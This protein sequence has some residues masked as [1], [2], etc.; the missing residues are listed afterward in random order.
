MKTGRRPVEIGV[1]LPGDAPGFSVK[2]ANH[3]VAGTDEEEIARDRGGREDSSARIKL[4]EDVRLNREFGVGSD[5][6]RRDA[7]CQ[8]QGRQQ[9]S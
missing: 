6:Y 9:S 5:D 2:G 8:D 3:A 7:N 1:V 4:P